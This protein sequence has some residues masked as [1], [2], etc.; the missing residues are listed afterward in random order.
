METFLAHSD[1]SFSAQ[2]V[3][4]IKEKEYSLLNSLAPFTYEILN[5][6]FTT[7]DITLCRNIFASGRKVNSQ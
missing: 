5:K 3:E 1:E 2:V 4:R 6:T 7:Y